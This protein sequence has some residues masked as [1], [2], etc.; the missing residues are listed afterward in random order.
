M[1]EELAG[2]DDGPATRYACSSALTSV[3]MSVRR[4]V[5]N[6]TAGSWW[7]SSTVRGR[8]LDGV[9]NGSRLT[10]CRSRASR[11]AVDDRADW[12][13]VVVGRCLD[14]VFGMFEDL[15]SRQATG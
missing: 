11:A 14:L 7:G 13:T 1:G 15:E 12:R 4:S 8:Q 9:V 5:R 2:G 6:A 10:R 3:R